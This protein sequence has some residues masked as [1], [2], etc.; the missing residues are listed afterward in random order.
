MYSNIMWPLLQMDNVE[1]GLKTFKVG[2]FVEVCY[3]NIWY[4]AKITKVY[5]EYSQFRIHYVG[6]KKK[7]DETLH[8][9]ATTVRWPKENETENQL[10]KDS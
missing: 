9:G 4:R 1:K 7:W 3:K 5:P 10:S 8:F 6:W 2:D